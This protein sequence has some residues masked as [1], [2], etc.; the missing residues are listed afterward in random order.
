MGGEFKGMSEFGDKPCDERHGNCEKR[1]DSQS[2][3]INRLFDSRVPWRVFYWTLGIVIALVFG[4]YGYTK[5]VSD[6][7]DK[8]VT[9]DDMREY[10]R[11]IIEAIKEG[12]K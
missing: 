10:Q 12:V 2:V 1:M 6:D 9:T 11:E 8:V 7:V 4:N 5:A 3:D